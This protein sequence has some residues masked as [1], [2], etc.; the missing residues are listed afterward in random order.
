ME[1]KTL[2]RLIKD[3]ISHLEGITG[4]FLIDTLPSADEIEMA[5]VRSNAL[6]K[7]LELLHK[8]AAQR[9]NALNGIKPIGD[10]LAEKLIL[11]EHRPIE[12]PKSRMVG[13]Y[14]DIINLNNTNREL[15]NAQHND[16]MMVDI[17]ASVLDEEP[18]DIQQDEDLSVDME[19]PLEAH[20]DPQTNVIESREEPEVVEEEPAGDQSADEVTLTIPEVPELN[21][22]VVAEDFKEVKKTLNETLGDSHQLVNDILSPEK[23][24]IGFQ[25]IPIN[26]IWDGIGIND[27]FLYI[28]ELFAN[29]SAKFENT[30]AALDKLVTIQDAVNYLKLN[31]K[32][33][34]TEASQ[35]FLVLVKRRFTKQ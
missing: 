24:E 14:H 23:I 22:E 13:D 27:R 19:E 16:G 21:E 31:F 6:L 3:D 11:S 12:L 18:E 5:L 10:P 29:S 1:V 8:I 32:W 17:N 25:I 33:T 34:K 30:V 35:K 4:E 26:S 2:L 20:D 28:R 15:V 7:E 9:E